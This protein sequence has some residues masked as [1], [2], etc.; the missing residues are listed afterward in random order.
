[1][2]TPDTLSIIT[3]SRNVIDAKLRSM[4]M[5]DDPGDG[6]WGDMYIDLDREEEEVENELET[7]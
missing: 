5:S 4:K 7:D 2:I 1:V 3:I 6:E